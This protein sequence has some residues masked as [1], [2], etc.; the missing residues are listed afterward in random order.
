M[1]PLLG[2]VLRVAA[3]CVVVCSQHLGLTI[4]L[5]LARTVADILGGR[6]PNVDIPPL[7]PDRSD[8]H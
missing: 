4:G 6:E 2:P 3:G 7:R 1:L 8:R 5:R